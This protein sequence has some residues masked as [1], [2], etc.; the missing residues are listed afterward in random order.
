MNEPPAPSPEPGGAPHTGMRPSNHTTTE[1]PVPLHRHHAEADPRGRRLAIL[2]ITALGVVY[3]D[4]GTSP[5]Y[6]LQECFKPEY[7]LTPTPENVYGVLSLILWSLIVIVSIKYIVFILRADN[8]GE[9]GIL[10]LLALIFQEEKEDGMG[11]TKLVL[12]IALGLFGAALLYGDGIITPAISV[13]GAMEGLQVGAPGFSRFVVPATLLILFTLFLFQKYGT[14]RVGGVFGPIMATWFVTLAALGIAEVVREPGILL[15]VNPWYAIRFFMANGLHGIVLLGAV[16]LSVTGA[17]ALYADMGHF[18]RKPIRTAW[19]GLVFP[20]LLLN[21]LGQGALILRDPSASSNPFYN[22]AP[23]W[24]FIPLLILA[25]LAA[26]VASQALISGA[27]S[28]TQQ[29]VQLGYSPR[30]TIIHTSKQEAGQIYI[31]E[32]NWLLMIG[33][34]AVVAGFGSVSRLGAA[35]GIAVTGTMAI[36]TILFHEIARSR[37]NWSPWRAGLLSGFFLAID[38]AFFGANAIKIEHGGWVPLALGLCIFTLLTTWKAGRVLLRRILEERSLPVAEFVD[39]LAKGSVVRVPGTAVFM[40]SESEGTPVVLLHHL[41][42]NKV[43]HEKTILLSVIATQVP[44]VP[45]SER[46]TVESLSSGIYRVKARYGF[47]ETPNVE[48]IRSR[49]AEAG[50]RTRRMDT[51]YYLGREQL[52]PTSGVGMAKWRKRLFA[53]MSRNARSATQYFG[54]PPN[55]VV[56]LGAQI[57]F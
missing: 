57:E 36:T 8:R 12:Y 4:I 24:F 18:G 19:F 20:A 43:L 5:L 41:K 6:A 51:T 11:R 35:Y 9:G 7:G 21:Y 50:I 46:I 47:M 39:S 22:L 15:A 37:W 48:D 3:G 56:E 30:V 23:G 52:I 1:N 32:V 40:T 49:L 54:I 27:F 17:E 10:A 45:S 53:V 14:A 55:R 38:L 2:T 33:C 25:T 31:P 44:E 29:C 26:I 13:L 42:H 16:V 28:I 34:L